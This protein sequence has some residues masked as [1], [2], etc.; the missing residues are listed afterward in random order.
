M[1]KSLCERLRE[2][3]G[4][5]SYKAFSQKTG[6]DAASFERWE[7]GT[8]DIK[9][10]ALLK[11]CSVFQV[12][13]DWLLGIEKE[14]FLSTA[15]CGAAGVGK[16]AFAIDYAKKIIAL[17]THGT[18]IEDLKAPTVDLAVDTGTGT[19]VCFTKSHEA[20]RR[21]IELYD[22]DPVLRSA[23]NQIVRLKYPAED[24]F[25]GISDGTNQEIFHSGLAAESVASTHIPVS[26]N[27]SIHSLTNSPRVRYPRG[28]SK[29][30]THT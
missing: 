20:R 8:S 26:A 5:L 25:I 3:R 28:R 16:S 21:L 14:P 27:A 11:L 23:I 29:P 13:S 19:H 7:K 30:K 17:G 9:S 24:K 18:P 4:T 15:V 22:S 2:L 6:L 10:D 1:K 12:S